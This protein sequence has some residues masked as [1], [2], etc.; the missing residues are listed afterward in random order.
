MCG[1]LAINDLSVSTSGN[2]ESFVTIAGTPHSHIIDP[3]MDA[4]AD[5]VPSATVIAADCTTADA[6][7]TAVSVLGPDVLN[8]LGQ[9]GGLEVMFILGSPEAPKVAATPGFAKYYLNGPPFERR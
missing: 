9:G 7:S 1:V 3:R 5:Q 6:W 2:Y 8:L 4:P